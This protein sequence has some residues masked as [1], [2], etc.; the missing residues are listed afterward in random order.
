M[1]PGTGELAGNGELEDLN[2]WPLAELPRLA[3][4]DVRSS[5]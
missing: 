1:A 4:V 2:W 3:I 5:C